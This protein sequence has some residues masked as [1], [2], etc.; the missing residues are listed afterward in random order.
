[1]QRP[2][3]LQTALL[4]CCGSLLAGYSCFYTADNR[5]TAFSVLGYGAGLLVLVLTAVGLAIKASGTSSASAPAPPVLGGIAVTPRASTVPQRRPTIGQ[6]VVL[7][8]CGFLLFF[9]SCGGAI[10]P[11]NS[12]PLASLGVIG[13]I[14]GAVFMLWGVIILVMA[15]GRAFSRR[16]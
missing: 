11:G 2:S 12:N 9:F 14:A 1:M 10:L 7:G 8:L 16:S 3:A 13:M 4:M 15:I 5:S 6:S